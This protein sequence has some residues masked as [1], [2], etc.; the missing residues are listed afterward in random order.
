M[1]KDTLPERSWEISDGEGQV[2][3]QQYPVRWRPYLRYTERDT[4]T[5]TLRRITQPNPWE[6]A[7]G[8]KPLGRWE[9]GRGMWAG[10]TALFEK[11]ENMGEDGLEE[12]LLNTE[13]SVSSENCK[14]VLQPDQA[15]CPRG[16]WCDSRAI[17]VGPPRPLQHFP[18][19]APLT[20]PISLVLQGDFDAPSYLQVGYAPPFRPEWAHHCRDQCFRG[21]VLLFLPCPR[22]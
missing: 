10:E 2:D 4:H 9:S 5:T 12:H 13:T 11:G 15:A 19:I 21:K 14:Q 16:R 1:I 22:R 18:K 6:G 20:S 3:K 8:A 17:I 7:A